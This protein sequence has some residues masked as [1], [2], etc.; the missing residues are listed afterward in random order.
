MPSR[1]DVHLP[2]YSYLPDDR[3]VRSLVRTILGVSPK[4]GVEQSIEVQ[5]I[6][7]AGQHRF[8]LTQ[9]FGAKL[10]LDDVP[11][12]GRIV[13]GCRPEALMISIALSS[14]DAIRR[15]NV[16]ELAQI[17]HHQRRTI[18]SELLIISFARDPIT[19]PKFPLD[20][21]WTPEMASSMTTARAGST[22]SSFAAIKKVGIPC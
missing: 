15:R 8:R 12:V 3:T 19:R 6:G 10:F 9:A 18:V 22:P 21:A 13:A 20:P 1:S 5:D 16:N 17:A 2:L 7:K 14:F 11:L 4:R